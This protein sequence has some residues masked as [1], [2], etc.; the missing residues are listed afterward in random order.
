MVFRYTSASL[1]FVTTLCGCS[2]LDC[3]SWWGRN[4]DGSSNLGRKP[5]PYQAGPIASTYNNAGGMP[6]TSIAVQP[7]VTTQVKP[8]IVTTS[9]AQAAP[10]STEPSSPSLV[11]PTPPLQLQGI[12]PSQYQPPAP[13][14]MQQKPVGPPGTFMSPQAIPDNQP[15][16]P[17]PSVNMPQ[18]K[19]PTLDLT[20]PSTSMNTAP[21]SSPTPLMLTPTSSASRPEMDKNNTAIA[22]P[23]IDFPTIP[24]PA[25][26][27]PLN[28][29]PPRIGGIPIK[30]EGLNPGTVPPPIPA[31]PSVPALDVK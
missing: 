19:G 13:A 8:P 12:S 23:A 28:I 27:A 2:S 30:S 6:S 18:V 3:G 29:S 10:V 11:P 21:P 9:P 1:L 25:I 17:L 4:T 5:V 7:P 24:S 26:H 15:S 20:L 14:E 22:P 16:I 31:P